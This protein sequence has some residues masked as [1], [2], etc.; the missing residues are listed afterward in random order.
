MDQQH[1][2]NRGKHTCES[3]E[4]TSAASIV[5]SILQTHPSAAESALKA[6]SEM[7][8]RVP[9]YCEENVWR[10]AFR[11][12]YQQTNELKTTTLQY[13]V[14]FVSNPKACV[15]IYQQRA[16]THPNKPIFWD[17]HVILL[18]T[19]K[20]TSK[21]YSNKQQP[22]CL[23]WDMDSHLPCPC[24]F[25]RY[26]EAAFWDYPQWPPE[27]R[28]YF[29]V[30]DAATYLR[31]FSSDRSHMKQSDGTWSAPPP[32]Y[33]CILQPQSEANNTELPEQSDS[34]TPPR[35][36]G[37]NTLRRYM[38]ITPAEVAASSSKATSDIDGKRDKRR[39]CGDPGNDVVDHPFGEILSLPRFRERFGK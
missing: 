30:V 1:Q 17:Y 22:P 13:Y 38:T 35:T 27:Y 15:P 11:K 36:D 21:N 6:P 3:A 10:L 4:T 2:E 5:T 20:S 25:D 7:S 29:R 28:P 37:H 18:S 23:V 32:M 19:Q 24:P 26:M 39:N 14:I 9:C 16:S 33:D 8:L 31:Y 12:L 34:L